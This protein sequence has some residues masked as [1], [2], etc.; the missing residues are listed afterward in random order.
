MTAARAEREIILGA[1]VLVTPKLDRTTQ[2][3]KRSNY[4]EGSQ[5]AIGMPL[6]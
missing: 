5:N 3:Q 1:G 6:L 2:K 4:V